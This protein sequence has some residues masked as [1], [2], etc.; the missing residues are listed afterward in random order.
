MCTS[1]YRTSGSYRLERPRCGPPQY[2]RILDLN[3]QRIEKVRAG[4]NRLIATALGK[5]AGGT[6]ALP[7]MV[8]IRMLGLSLVF[9]SGYGC[10]CRGGR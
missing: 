9:G 2:R 8:A 10:G 5:N 6:P 1:R 4:T 7:R 3:C